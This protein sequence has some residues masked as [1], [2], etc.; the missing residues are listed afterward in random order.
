MIANVLHKHDCM[1]RIIISVVVTIK[2]SSEGK[3]K[4]L[5]V[6]SMLKKL[7]GKQML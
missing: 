3:E 1:H 7:R 6:V 4:Y 2:L 5:V